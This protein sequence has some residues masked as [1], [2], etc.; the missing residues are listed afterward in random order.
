[1]FE[2]NE[3]ILQVADPEL[4]KHILVKD[5]NVFADRHSA[6]RS[7]KH[8]I[9][10]KILTELRGDDWKRVRSIASPVFT[11]GKMRKMYPM[12]RRSVEGF[13]NTLDTYAKDM[14]VINAKD[15]FD[16]YT[17]DVIS[18]C[19]FAIKSDAFKD[20]N[21][22]F[23]VNATVLSFCSY[24]L[25][26]NP[27]VQQKLYEE[28]MSSLDTNGEIDYE[29]L[30]KLPFL[31][32]VIAE[33]L[34]LHTPTIKIGR[35]AAQDYRLGNTGITV[36][37]GQIVEIPVYAIH[38]SEEYYTNPEKFISDRFLPENRHKIIPYTYLPFSSGPR[39]CIG[40][41]IFEGNKPLLQVAEPEL[42]K[43]ILVKDFPVF[44][45]RKAGTGN[46]KHPIVSLFLTSV[47]GRDWK[48]I[49]SIISPAFSA[50]K[51]KIMYLLVRQSV[52]GFINTLD[53]YAKDK[54]EI[55]A[56]DMY[57]CLTMDVISNCAFATK[58][59]AFKDPNDEKEKTVDK[60]E[61]DTYEAHHINEGEEELR[62]EKKVLDIKVSNKSLTE[63]EIIAQGILFF[64]TGYLT[65]ATTLA[66]CSYELALNPDVQ[67]KLYEEV[68]S[69]MDTNGE[70]DYEVL[71]K[72]PFLDAV[73]AETL[74]LH[75]PSV[76]ISRIATKDYRL[77]NTGIF[78][79]KG[80]VVEIPIHA[81][82]HSEDYY[83]NPEM[84]IPDR[85]LPE[86]RHKIIPY[87]YLP[88][89]SGP[90]NC[91]GMRN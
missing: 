84:F 72:L 45:D 11:S 13:L 66:F 83:P 15:M 56:L 54:R 67:Q 81:I 35:I 60:D 80:D 59:D 23:V 9:A 64:A 41:S 29:V 33:T 39:K 58:T 85:F 37:K 65:T 75:P 10:G 7:H 31:D 27:D 26:L 42:L 53:T 79:H 82:H 32:A 22:P 1:I 86:N 44:A 52:E 20:P 57:G 50:S 73:I 55:N 69:S 28:V 76:K 34:R 49:R 5:F 19:A 62:I 91:I 16:C 8:P 51:M 63:N 74:R 70:I 77:G 87:T 90:R 36:Y 6:S 3:P 24:E 40:M 71:I 12:V 17:M 2:G 46:T 48:R 38:H 78:L 88:F 30:I 4:I 47:Q 61:S 18:N 21:N 14:R 25:A 68:M 43:H 89:G